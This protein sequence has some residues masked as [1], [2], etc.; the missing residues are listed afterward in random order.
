[1]K[2]LIGSELAA[3]AAMVLALGLAACGTEPEE[4]EEH[5]EPHEVELVMGSTVLASYE[6]DE[7]TWE[8]SL[9]VDAGAETGQI[10]VRFLDDEGDELHFEDEDEPV[11]LEVD[12]ADAAIAEFVLSA[13][14]AFTGTFR[15]KTA[16]QTGVTIK[17]MHGELGQGHPDL[18][19]T[20]LQAT[21][22][23]GG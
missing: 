10:E 14:G 7:T 16:G 4:E 12:V 15:G 2:K 23:A 17:L 22:N 8:G 20:P 21:V 19:T 11:Y 9:E 3:V 5:H 1:M 6:V 13:P 18:Q